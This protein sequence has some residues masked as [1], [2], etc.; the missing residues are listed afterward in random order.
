MASIM[1]D[2]MQRTLP[3]SDPMRQAILSAIR[4]VLDL[5]G[6]PEDIEIFVSV[7]GSRRMQ[8]LNRRERG[9]NRETDVLSFPC[10][11][12]EGK[13]PGS[14]LAVEGLDYN[15]D[16]KNIL[17]GDIIISLP[18]AAQQAEEYGHSLMR[19]LG[20]LAAHGTLHLLGYDHMTPK[21]QQQMFALQ[22]KALEHAN[23]KR[24]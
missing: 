23:L 20:F 14:F 18:K 19:E 17:L 12:W 5:A 3:F 21:D 2:N 16:T 6:A 15:P 10:I 24:E 4:S 1:L 8:Q 11:D 13:E 7:I 22:E 9:I